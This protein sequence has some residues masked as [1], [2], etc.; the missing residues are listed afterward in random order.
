MATPTVQNQ[1]IGST[2]FVAAGN[3]YQFLHNRSSWGGTDLVITMMA[4]YPAAASN[5][6]MKWNGGSAL[7]ALYGPWSGAGAGGDNTYVCSWHVPA[8]AAVNGYVRLEVSTTGL[9]AAIIGAFDVSDIKVGDPLGAANN[10]FSWVGNGNLD[11]TLTPEQSNSLILQVCHAS[12]TN[13]F[14]I[15]LDDTITGTGT[16]SLSVQQSPAVGRV[17]YRK[18][19][20][21]SSETYRASK[22][23][24]GSGFRNMVFELLQQ[25]SGIVQPAFNWWM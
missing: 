14:P 20:P 24:S 3:A 16:G 18:D 1:T 13:N 10:G 7:T 17:G 9:N 21:T 5:L 2:G 23:G 12:N 22:T 25:P 19:A 8:A 11:V 6:V 4:N 15:T